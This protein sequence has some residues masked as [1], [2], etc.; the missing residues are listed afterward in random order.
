M[1]SKL[2][3]TILT[4]CLLTACK[5][6]YTCE[7]YNPGGFEGSTQIRDTKKSAEQKCAD[8]ASKQAWSETYCKLK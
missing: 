8:S 5:K 7:C 6:E 1:K 4:I 3:L 2:V